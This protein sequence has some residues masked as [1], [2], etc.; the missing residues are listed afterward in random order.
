MARN[1][2]RRYDESDFLLAFQF[3][4]ENLVRTLARLALIGGVGY[5]G[6]KAASSSYAGVRCKSLSRTVSSARSKAR[7][8]Q[9]NLRNRMRKLFR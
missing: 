6:Y 8:A 7:K 3:R 2:L 4:I 1:Q 5:L 9:K